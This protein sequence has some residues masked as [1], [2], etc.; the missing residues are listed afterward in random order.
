MPVSLA[1]AALFV[2]VITMSEVEEDVYVTC[3][4]LTVETAVTTLTLWLVLVNT[5]CDVLLASL[6][7]TVLLLASSDVGLAVEGDV[8]V[9]AA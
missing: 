9:C 6:L 3:C 5:A 4:P 1:R 8:V 7:V 2:E